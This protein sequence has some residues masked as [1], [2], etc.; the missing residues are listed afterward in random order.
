VAGT[1]IGDGTFYQYDSNFGVEV[2]RTTAVLSPVNG[3]ETVLQAQISTLKFPVGIAY[4]GSYKSALFSVPVEYFT[5]KDAQYDPPDTLVARVIDYFGGTPT[6]VADGGSSGSLP[7]SFALQ[8]NYPNPFNPTT[9]ISYTVYPRRNSD[10]SPQRTELSVF[11]VLG[12]RVKTL[13]D[14][15]QI[16][17]TY[18]VEWAGDNESGNSVA[19]GIY[20]YRLTLGDESATRKMLLVK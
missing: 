11:N 14:K 3:G 15:V 4:N 8:Q 17:G 5:S 6:A 1:E 9:T 16:P 13:V 18:E 12:Q 20:F 10:G 2:D 19:S 7:T